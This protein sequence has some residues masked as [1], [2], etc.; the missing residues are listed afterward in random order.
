MRKYINLLLGRFGLIAY[1][2]KK[3]KYNTTE[4]LKE[5]YKLDEYDIAYLK[6]KSGGGLKEKLL[7]EGKTRWLDVGCGGKFESNFFYMDTF[8]SN[9]VSE[10]EKYFRIDIINATSSELEKLGTF[11]LVRMQHVF[12]HFTP[13]DGLKVLENCA[14]LLNSDGYILISTPDL[15]RFAYLY[16]SGKIKEDF[17]WARHRVEENSPYSFFFSV[18][19]H[20][21][22]TE[23]HQWCYDAEGLMYQVER[24]GKF[25][26]IAE[27]K[28][29]DSLANISFTHNRPSQDVC[30]VAQRH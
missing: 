30:V 23:K 15:K 29:G 21:V 28:L 7:N 2:K 26:N 11:D 19:A 25:K 20:S 17:N 12:E 4:E 13:E 10:K 18:F 14:K 22:Q 6:G 5:L 27:I 9:I 3:I 8:P 1:S 24:T 16:L